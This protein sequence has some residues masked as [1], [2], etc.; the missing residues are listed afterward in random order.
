VYTLHTAIPA[1]RAAVAISFAH[2]LY[3]SVYPPTGPTT[4]TALNAG[5]PVHAELVPSGAWDTWVAGRGVEGSAAARAPE[6]REAASTKT[7]AS[8]AARAERH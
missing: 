2:A 3:R 5:R 4:M 1:S 8:M 6:V 7:S